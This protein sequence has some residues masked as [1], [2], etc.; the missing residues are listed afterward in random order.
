MLFT[1]GGTLSTWQV[2]QPQWSSLEHVCMVR[3]ARLTG[4]VDL[5]A[6]GKNDK[7]FLQCLSYTYFGVE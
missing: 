1:T 3:Y 4:D 2:C 5:D 7:E 6:H